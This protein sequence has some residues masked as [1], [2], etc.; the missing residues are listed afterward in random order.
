M[1]DPDFLH[2]EHL[3]EDALSDRAAS[4]SIGEKSQPCQHFLLRFAAPHCIV[5]PGSGKA[6]YRIRAAGK[7]EQEDPIAVVEIVDNK[8]ALEAQP[9]TTGGLVVKGR[10]P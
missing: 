9:A 5:R 2:D 6:T 1:F 3:L 10:N 8:G 7:P 4:D